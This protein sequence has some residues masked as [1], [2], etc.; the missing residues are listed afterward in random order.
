MKE[1]FDVEFKEILWQCFI[2]IKKKQ[3]GNGILVPSCWVFCLV[4]QVN[5]P[6]FKNFGFSK[7]REKFVNSAVP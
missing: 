5:G 7:Q 6:L 1:G 3:I 4:V 2:L